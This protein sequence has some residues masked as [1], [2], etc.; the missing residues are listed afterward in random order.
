MH[1][2]ALYPI[3]APLLYGIILRFTDNLTDAE[4]V[5]SN[6]F[7]SIHLNLQQHSEDNCR[8]FTMMVRITL[9]ECA[10]TLNISQKEILF[11][12][13]PFFQFP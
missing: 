6:S 7:T 9:E 13:R 10:K 4:R 1:A 12:I 8:L 3:Y 5:L 11:E 2:R